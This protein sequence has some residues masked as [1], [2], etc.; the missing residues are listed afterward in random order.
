MV[1]Q[2]VGEQAEAAQHPPD[3]LGPEPVADPA[4]VF[5]E[6]Y[7]ELEAAA[8]D[9][10]PAA[11]VVAATPVPVIRGLASRGQVPQDAA[12]IAEDLRRIRN[13][14]AHGAR[15][16]EPVDAE[17]LAITARSLAATCRWAGPSAK[18]PSASAPA[19]AR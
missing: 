15:R 14:V 17:N 13:E 1:Q 4:V 12:R 11:K 5:L 9:A 7:R 18:P 16:L 6:A 3:L 2:V 10:G 19:A 8:K